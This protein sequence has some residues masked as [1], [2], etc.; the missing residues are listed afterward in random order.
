MISRADLDKTFNNSDMR[1]RFTFS[2]DNLYFS[3]DFANRS[4]RFTMLGMSL[5]NLLDMNSPQDLLRGLTNIMNEYD[6]SKEDNDK[7]KM[8]SICEHDLKVR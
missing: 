2:R 1:R 3:F 6:Q 4:L 8:V 5:S 7:S